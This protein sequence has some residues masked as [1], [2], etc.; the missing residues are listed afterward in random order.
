MNRNRKRETT[1][2]PKSPNETQNAMLWDL[3]RRVTELEE[4]AGNGPS[5]QQ[6]TRAQI[7]RPIP[8]PTKE[9]PYG[10][11]KRRPGEE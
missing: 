8:P 2:T 6:L 7:S 10:S 4:E 9:M 3:H 1:M 11:N 5:E